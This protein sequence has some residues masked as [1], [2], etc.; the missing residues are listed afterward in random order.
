MNKEDVWALWPD[1]FMCPKDE[2]EEYN[3]KSDDFMWVVVESYD[4]TGSPIEFYP[5]SSH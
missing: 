4:E 2:V 5:L 1:D 3:F